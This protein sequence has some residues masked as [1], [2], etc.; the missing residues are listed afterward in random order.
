MLPALPQHRAAGGSFLGLADAGKTQ[1]SP[2]HPALPRCAGATGAA[3]LLLVTVL[4]VPHG[5]SPCCTDDPCDTPQGPH[6]AGNTGTWVGGCSGVSPP[7][8]AV[9]S[10]RMLRAES[11]RRISPWGHF[12][13]SSSLS[14]V[15]RHGGHLWPGWRFVFL[16]S[17]KIPCKEQ[18]YKSRGAADRWWEDTVL[19]Q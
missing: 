2:G 11:R 12:L 1:R 10:G 13:P 19:K 18:E 16:N 6:R 5:F 14:H 15:P 17:R 3:P 8:Q 7:N 4:P 9:G